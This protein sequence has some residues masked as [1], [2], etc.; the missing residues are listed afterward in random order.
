MAPAVVTM[1]AWTAPTKG[2]AAVEAVV[3]EAAAVTTA[4]TVTTWTAPTKGA[5]AVEAAVTEAAAAAVTMTT[6]VEACY[7]SKL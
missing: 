6:V 4:V 5:A 2:A 1:T 3:T 7:C